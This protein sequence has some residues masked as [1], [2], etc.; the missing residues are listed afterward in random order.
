MLCP[1]TNLSKSDFTDIPKRFSKHE[2][3]SNSQELFQYLKTNFPFFTK[4]VQVL[5]NYLNVP[6]ESKGY[7]NEFYYNIETEVENQKKLI[8]IFLSEEFIRHFVLNGTLFLM[9]SQHDDE[10]GKGDLFIL[11]DEKGPRIIT[12]EYHNFQL[13]I[14][15]NEYNCSIKSKKKLEIALHQIL[16]SAS[17]IYLKW[18]PPSKDICPSS[19]AKFLQ[20]A[21]IILTE[22]TPEFTQIR[23]QPNYKDETL[24]YPDLN[25]TAAEMA[26]EPKQNRRIFGRGRELDWG[27]NARY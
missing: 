21:S 14:N 18:I 27:Y 15:I 26:G 10:D 2:T 25:K 9:S 19:I 24:K 7:F 4:I 6:Y 16:S 1:E 22:W 12:H 3:F 11:N 5:P 13:N 8:P 20:E 17:T 23:K